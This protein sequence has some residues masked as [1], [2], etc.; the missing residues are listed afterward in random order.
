[1][2]PE[3]LTLEPAVDCVPRK[4]PMLK[5]NSLCQGIRRWSLGVVTRL[6]GWNLHE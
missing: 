1:M 4:V 3:S 2:N 6:G 5:P